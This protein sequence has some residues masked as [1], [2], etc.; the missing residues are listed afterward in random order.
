MYKPSKE[1]VT[2][3]SS[4]Y[5]LQCKLSHISMISFPI[6]LIFLMSVMIYG[7]VGLLQPKDDDTQMRTL[8]SP[9]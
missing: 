8:R 7:S 5:F 3:N 4:P 9:C 6:A 2:D 1:T